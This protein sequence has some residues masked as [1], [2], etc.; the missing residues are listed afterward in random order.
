MNFVELQQEVAKRQEALNMARLAEKV[1][2]DRAYADPQSTER[3]QWREYC[4]TLDGMEYKN[5]VSLLEE[6]EYRYENR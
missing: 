3:T 1:F 2:M 5:C 4:S 6:A